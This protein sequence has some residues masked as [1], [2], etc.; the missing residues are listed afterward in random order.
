[1]DIES[2]SPPL[3]SE[4]DEERDTSRLAGGGGQM[5]ALMRRTDWSATPLGPV[6]GWP[7]SLRIAV[8]IV[9]N[10][11][12]PMFVWWGRELIN[13]YNDGY[14]PMLG[15]R[16]P[17]AL[18]QPAAQVW[19]EIWDTV[20]PQ[21]DA[22]LNEGRSSWN[23]ELLLV[24]ER[25]GYREE[26]FFTFSYSP[27]PD[28]HGG[29][30]GVYCAVME[31]TQRV[32]GQRRV[33]ALQELAARTTA[34]VDSERQACESVTNAL[35]EHR[36]DVSFALLSLLEEQ[37]GGVRLAGATGLL[38]E[39]PAAPLRV[40]LDSRAAAAWP[41][42][43]VLKSGRAEVAT[44]LDHRFGG[45]PGGAWPE[46]T[47]TAMVLPLSN[48]AQGGLAG[49]LVAG[50][51]PRRELD[52]AYRTFFDLLASHIATAIIRG[53]ASDEER[54]RTEALA[55]LDRTKTEFFSNVSHEFR[56]PLTLM[57]GPLDDALSE[58]DDQKQ[59]EHLEVAQRNA[60][61]LQKLVNT[62]LDFSRIEAGRI[63][64]CYE[65]TELGRLTT[66]LASSFRSAC[67]KAGI[68]LVIDCPAP[69]ELV[70]VD[71]DMWEKV[72]L[73]LLSNAFKFTHEGQILVSLR[74][75]GD[76]A[77]LKVR[78]T[79]I[80]IPSDQLPRLFERF[81]RIAGA[82]GRTQ[83]GSGIGL[84]MVRE[85]VRLHGGEVEVQSRPGEGSTFAVTVPLGQSH[86]P[87]DRIRAP[88]ERASTALGAAPY[89]QE[90][91]R[92]LPSDSDLLASEHG[93]GTARA[94]AARILVVDDN[95][96]MRDYLV[97]LLQGRYRVETVAD[98]EAALEV[99][100]DRPPDLVLTDV[101][102]PRLDGFGLLRA[103]RGDA[104]TQALPVILLS[105]RAGEEAR[106]EGL[107]AGADDYLVKPFGAREL[108]A[109]VGGVIALATERK[110]AAEAL[111]RSDERYRRY[112]S[113]GLI[114]MAITS[115][116]K[117]C[118]EVND[119]L[120]QMLGYGRD[121]LL[122]M[123]WAELT[124]PDDRAADEAQF[125]RVMRGEIDGYTLDKRWIKKDGSIVF[126]TI[127]VA[128]LRAPDGSVDHFV[129]LAQDITERKRAEAALR[130]SE[131]NLSADLAA[132]VRVQQISN[133]LVGT[134]AGRALLQEILDAAID[135]TGADM[136]T[137]QL[138]RH[139]SGMLE[140]VAS[141]GFDRPF[142]EFFDRVHMG[143][144]T[145][146][147]A[148]ESLERV[149][150]ED[151]TTSPVFVGTP[152]LDAVMAAGVLAV[153][154]TPLVNRAGR[155]MGM[156]S[157]HYRSVRR[158]GERDLRVVDTL[159]RQAAD[160]IERTRADE[161]LRESEGRFRRVFDC[162]IVP[163]GVWTET[164]SIV[165]ANEALLS[166]VGYGRDDLEAGRI[167]WQ[168][169]TPPE[170]RRP[171]ERPMAD[172][173]NQGAGSPWEGE[174][175]HRDG[176][177]VPVLIGSAAFD[178]TIDRGV[179]FALDL[180]E[181]KRTEE[182]LREADRA[183]S[184][185][186]A[187]L[188]HELR[189]PMAPIKNS[190]AILEHAAPGSEASHRAQAVIGRQFEQLTRLVD[191]LLDV[192]RISRNKL[193]L[194]RERFELGEL[195]RSTV[196]DYRPQF[197]T[198]GIRLELRAAADE[199]YVN[200]DRNRVAQAVG[201]LLQ[202]AAKFAGRGGLTTV[203]VTSESERGGRAVVRVTDNGVGVAPDM[204]T[205]LF[206]P[207]VQ[208]EHSLARSKGGLGL[209]L[210]L[211]KAIIEDHGGEI[212]AHSEGLGRGTEMVFRL[213]LAEAGEAPASGPQVRP[214]LGR[215]RVLVIEDNPDAASSLRD[216]LELLWSQCEVA[217]A[218]SGQDGLRVAHTFHPDLV[219][220]DIGLP[221]L[222]GYQVARAFRADD[223]LRSARLVAL[224]GY[225]QPEDI[226]QASA[227]GFEWHLAK[228]LAL[229]KLNEILR[230][231]DAA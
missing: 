47:Q 76:H 198:N 99:A 105:A 59:R 125:E 37:G 163:M 161:A 33:K 126:S 140:I 116:T 212:A 72:V 73:N 193:E 89:V 49:F 28:D 5:G 64:A 19:A 95:A 66:E 8:Q 167:G 109:R 115:P 224:S 206:H 40:D 210:A 214:A 185:F 113:M 18:G 43:A 200:A 4:G 100:R 77:V 38:P 133:R 120:C 101:M 218:H 117:A 91:L 31:E 98:G 44:D 70:H 50:V 181:R 192:T 151:V 184:D 148:L 202:N 175:I 82:A 194:Q 171:E 51:S 79:G 189:N 9:L 142:L 170:R 222:D 24:M 155:L 1:M 176:H 123:N 94:D 81:H 187:A 60:L 215:R 127:S 230:V 46:P 67:E 213:P 147:A 110:R 74:T 118:V 25:K 42:G 144:G 84:A 17:V 209:G 65:A 173:R 71:R 102:M 195:I 223:E 180:S 86:L 219:F 191:D 138:L 78:D 85:L 156:L 153:Q 96:D 2:Q 225:A 90:A 97:R 179:F 220:C 158:P 30:G 14:V 13:I 172:M 207:F 7:Q 197:D 106:I 160:W 93:P 68:E 92:W 157:T 143:L 111:H 174:W 58:I 119:Q 20:G 129:G 204:L 16:H 211:V 88:R 61:R 41:F 132:M 221:E 56:T 29:I 165:E 190:L 55:E 107:D 196:E 135:I 217:V 137:I 229:E 164:G 57:L 199:L 130:D 83:E 39:S 162:N 103:I 231:I 136:G 112:F 154:S 53:R 216:L 80:G 108:M 75:A 12:Y 114:G 63:E 134:G 131:R 87:A 226:R 121:E 205:R 22:V 21:A 54:R 228:P 69:T 149:V 178:G 26:A 23:E 45:L 128:C 124:H 62:L 145:C 177:R 34:E 166:M 227:A 183:K 201:N 182:V 122:R 186:L 10:S 35:S 168:T 6:S 139:D 3:S 159:A 104:R 141:R 27:V 169:L 152:S 48:A 11:R 188:S 208:A 203:T 146:G 36:L 15:H 52:D 32:I 150:V